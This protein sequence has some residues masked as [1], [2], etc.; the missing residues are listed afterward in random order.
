MY[1]DFPLSF[2]TLVRFLGALVLELQLKTFDTLPVKHLFMNRLNIIE[3]VTIGNRTLVYEYDKTEVCYIY[4]ILM[5]YMANIHK[6]LYM[7]GQ[8][9]SRSCA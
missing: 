7:P 8:S 3:K 1:V 2:K 4:A 5:L 6:I 9:M